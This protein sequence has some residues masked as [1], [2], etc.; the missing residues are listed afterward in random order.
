MLVP[1]GGVVE[2]AAQPR[3]GAAAA[4]VEA[5]GDEVVGDELVGDELG[6]DVVVVEA[7]GVL[8]P[9]QE[10]MSSPRTTVDTRRSMHRALDRRLTGHPV[11][12]CIWL[13]PRSCPSGSHHRIKLPRLQ[14]SRLA[15]PGRPSRSQKSDPASLGNDLARPGGVGREGSYALKTTPTYDSQR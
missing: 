5:G 4:T 14:P 2:V 15:R 9:P 7:A 6:D 3:L 13:L 11:V 10:E 12:P 8:D 1:T